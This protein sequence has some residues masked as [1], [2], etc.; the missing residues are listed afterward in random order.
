[1]APGAFGWILGGSGNVKA[2]ADAGCP[3]NPMLISY[4]GNQTWIKGIWA[5]Q[6]AGPE[7]ECEGVLVIEH[8]GC[9]GDDLVVVVFVWRVESEC[10]AGASCNPH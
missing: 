5:G 8:D 9:I 6:T 3:E 2:D 1:M 7:R 4:G 10:A